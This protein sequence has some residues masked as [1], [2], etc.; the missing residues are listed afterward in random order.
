MAELTHSRAIT[1]SAHILR[2]IALLF[3][4]ACLCALPATNPKLPWSTADLVVWLAGL[5]FFFW[6]VSRLMLKQGPKPHERPF[7]LFVLLLVSY[8]WVITSFP[9]AVVDRASGGI[10]ELD[11]DP[12][13]AFGTID[14]P[15]SVPYMISASAIMMVFLMVL[16]FGTEKIG[17]VSLACAI[18]IS[19]LT[20]AL[21]GLCLHQSEDLSHIWNQNQVPGFVF[22][23]FWYH[24]NA[25][26]FLNLCWPV[27]LWLALKVHHRQSLRPAVHQLSLAFLLVALLLQIT[28]VLVNVSKT[29]HVLLLLQ[30]LL[31]G[32][33]WLKSG[34]PIL[35]DGMLTK[36]RTWLILLILSILLAG[37]VW[38]AGGSSL[39]DR[40]KAFSDRQFDDAGRGHAAMMALRIGWDADWTGT[41]PGTFEWVSAHYS[42]LDPVLKDGRWKHAHND[43]A[44][45]FAEWGWVGSFILSFGVFAII[46]QLASSLWSNASD[47]RRERSSFERRAG[48]ACCFTAVFSLLAHAMVDFPLQITATQF[49]FSVLIGLVIAMSVSSRATGRSR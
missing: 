40:W 24:G 17:R 5:A 27:S 11:K 9:S 15:S 31:L 43:Y 13:M 34:L 18:T 28:G 45:F 14:Q 38:L 37:S 10:L 1:K 48:L 3:L 42:V 29:G 8:G 49:Q 30:G 12:W 32:A 23:L 35:P 21:A 46:R 2:S 6:T 19:G 20:T 25:A 33:L 47:R 36:K 44:E 26:A 41:G 39:T 16:D 4:A 7:W 22:G